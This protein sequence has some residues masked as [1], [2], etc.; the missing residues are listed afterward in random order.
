MPG[1][2][3][4]RAPV[5]PLGAWGETQ[6]KIRA[7][8]TAGAAMA[9]VAGAVAAPGAG[10]AATSQS[11][12]TSRVTASLSAASSPHVPGMRIHAVNLH[13]Q[14]ARALQEHVAAGPRAGVVP[15]RNGHRAAAAATST[16]AISAASSCTEPSCNV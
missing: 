8:L 10:R 3:P 15:V 16:Q 4:T 14:F 13:T 9:A 5:G 7:L 12:D 11:A 1:P 2:R 6:L